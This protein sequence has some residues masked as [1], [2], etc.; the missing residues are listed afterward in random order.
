MA[1]N[2]P[3]HHMR[4]VFVGSRKTIH[5]VSNLVRFRL[6]W[7]RAAQKTI[8]CRYVSSYHSA[9]DAASYSFLIVALFIKLN[10]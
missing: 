4:T 10:P 8:P 1:I 7:T 5:G 3:R 2:A 9:Y 6:R